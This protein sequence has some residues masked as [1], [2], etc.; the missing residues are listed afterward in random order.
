MTIT[1]S[2]VN[3]APIAIG[4][5]ESRGKTIGTVVGLGAG[6]AYE[7]QDIF[8]NMDWIVENAEKKGNGG[9]ARVFATACALG[10]IA[11]VGAVG[12]FAGGLIGK[13][14]DRK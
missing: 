9:K 3:A 11:A 4:K 2:S 13:V 8:K 7:R 14:V 10:I 12:R 5:N 1:V 6:C